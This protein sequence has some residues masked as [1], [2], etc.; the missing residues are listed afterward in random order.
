MDH[1]RHSNIYNVP[2]YFNV[3][4]V[5]VGGLGAMTALVLAKMGVQQMS[6]WDGDTVSETNIPTQLHPV[7]DVGKEK[8]YSLA[9]TLEHFSDEIQLRAY[10]ER[11]TEEEDFNEFHLVIAAVDSIQARKDIWIAT[12]R[13][14]HVEWFIDMRMAAEELQ[15]FVVGMHE[16]QGVEHYH[17]LLFR[18]Q[19]DDVPE[20]TCTAKSTF[21]TAAIAS[22]HVGKILRD[23]V[24]RE[25]VPHRLVHYIANEYIRTFD[26]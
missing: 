22:G 1:T 7:S 10:P 11:I 8:V 19:E 14:L 15:I 23:I 17:E 4:L 16:L 24:R 5:G 20:L 13:S 6:I 18:L 3:A 2:P 26:L 9:E 21:Y 12:T 25:A